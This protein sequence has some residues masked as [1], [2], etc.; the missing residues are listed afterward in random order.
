VQD[1]DIEDLS[2]FGGANWGNDPDGETVL[3]VGAYRA[4]GTRHRRL[5]AAL[6]P[7]LVISEDAAGRAVL[8]ELVSE[9]AHDRPGSQAVLDRLLDWGLVCTLRKWFSGPDSQPPAWYRAHSDPAVGRALRAMHSAPAANWTVASLATEARVS[10]AWFAKR[11]S[12]LMGQSPLAYLTQWRMTLA[13]DMLDQPDATVASTA[14]RVGYANAFAF[15][16]AFKR[17][18]GVSPAQFSR[19]IMPTAAGGPASHRGRPRA[20]R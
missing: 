13:E 4:Q 12:E 16:A 8:D 9:V 14:K 3:A 18:R 17:V 19:G 11:F 2:E 7:V 20:T 5:L 1:C 6:P 10:R 15:S